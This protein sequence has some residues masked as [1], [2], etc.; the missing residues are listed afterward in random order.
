MQ[1]GEKVFHTEWPGGVLP[2]TDSSL[3]EK[4]G[5][6]NGSHAFFPS[7]TRRTRAA[8]RAF[9]P[10]GRALAALLVFFLMTSM[11]PTAG[12]EPATQPL[13]PEVLAH[14]TRAVFLERLEQLALA[15][16]GVAFEPQTGNLKRW[17]TPVITYHIE[18]RYAAAPPPATRPETLDPRDA[19]PQAALNAT[20]DRRL[21]TAETG[22]SLDADG[23]TAATGPSSALRSPPL[24]PPE[25]AIAMTREAFA[26]L[27][28]TLEPLGVRLEPEPHIPDILVEIVD[29]PPPPARLGASR[30]LAA[31]DG[32]LR[33]G[34]VVLYG[35]GLT[36][37]HIWREALYV[38]GL[39]GFARPGAPSVLWMPV[40]PSVAGAPAVAG[41]PRDSLADRGR[42]AGLASS[43]GGPPLPE[44]ALPA[45][46]RAVLALLYRPELAPG[47]TLEEALIVLEERAP[48]VDVP[49][50]P[51]VTAPA[52]APRL[53][54]E[55]RTPEP[56]EVRP[57]PPALFGPPAQAGE[58]R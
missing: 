29:D 24:A 16:S 32:A 31:A 41:G 33:R 50:V 22:A 43:A 36:L 58:S 48:D 15:R 40:A 14:F 7:E 9:V 38:L 26:A 45:L 34:R 6:A 46:D 5:G 28:E 30:L 18:T 17:T 25:E 44:A 49:D 52:Y 11:A 56:A 23:L 13:S 19:S 57:A 47:M 42:A 3:S 39:R 27:N 2:A 12:A 54:P 37:P 53:W 8:G 1:I 35:R 10:G 4:T 55:L 21:D 20:L 51:G